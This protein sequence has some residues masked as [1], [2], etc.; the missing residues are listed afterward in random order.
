MSAKP[1]TSRGVYAKDVL[2]HLSPVLYV[3][4]SEALNKCILSED[5]ISG[6]PEL[7]GRPVLSQFADDTCIGAIGDYSVFALF[8]ESVRG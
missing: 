2:C 7:G 5:E 6:P 4:F 8:R 1:S 3:L